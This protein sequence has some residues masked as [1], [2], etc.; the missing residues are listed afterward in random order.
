MKIFSSY[1]K[2]DAVPSIDL[3]SN[4]SWDL[5]YTWLLYLGLVLCSPIKIQK[6]LLP[7]L[8]SIINGNFSACRRWTN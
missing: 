5:T 3:S 6:I 4:P 2:V 8:M 1:A 7:P